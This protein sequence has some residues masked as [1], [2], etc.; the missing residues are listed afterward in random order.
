MRDL[1]RR[2]ERLEAKQ[3]AEQP[4]QPNAWQMTPEE[5]GQIVDVLFEAGG[6]SLVEAVLSAGCALRAW[7]DQGQQVELTASGITDLLQAWRG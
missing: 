1:H 2:L 5:A 7:V 4:D 6:A 3:P